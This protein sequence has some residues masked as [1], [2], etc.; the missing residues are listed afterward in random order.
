MHRTFIISLASLYAEVW[1]LPR[2]KDE[3]K[4]QEIVAGVKLEPFQ[5]KSSKKIETDESLKKEQVEQQNEPKE[6]EI[7][8]VLK[9]LHRYFSSQKQNFKMKAIDFEKDDD[10]NFHIDFISATANLRARMYSIPEVD[11]LRVKAIAGRI[12]PAIA[13]TTSCV[14]G[15]VSLELLKLVLGLELDKFKN[16]FMNLALP[17]LA[18]SEPG[19]AERKKITEKFS[20]TLWDSWDV[21]QG[22]ITLNQFIQYFADK[23]GLTVAGVFKGTTMIYVPFFP[24]HLKRKPMKMSELLKRAPGSKY[25]DLIVTFTDEKDQDVSGPPIRFFYGK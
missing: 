23:Y 4:I 10:T 20:Y 6:E 21:K 24:A 22:D 1:G 14:A 17:L 16:L 5:P 15:C 25:D 7:E 8:D 11:R 13:T 3:A 2:H 9:E 12:M 18:F 19:V